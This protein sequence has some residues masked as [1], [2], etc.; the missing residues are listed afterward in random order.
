MA[1]LLLQLSIAPSGAEQPCL[2]ETLKWHQQRLA[3]HNLL[4]TVQILNSLHE[5]KSGMG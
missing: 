5:R 2:N 4:Q 3:L 1:S